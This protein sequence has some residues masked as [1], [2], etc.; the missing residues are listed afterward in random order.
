M[1]EIKRKTWDKYIETLRKLNDAAADAF[2][3][4]LKT[5]EIVTS[6]QRADAIMYA[7]GLATRY[8]EASAEFSARMYEAVARG[9][10]KTIEAALPAET[11]TYGEVAKTVNGCLKQSTNI[12]LIGNSIGRLVKQAG[13]DTVCQNAI[14][15][16]AEWAWVPEGDSCA[17]CMMLASN[18]WQRASKDVLK[19]NHAEHIHANCDCTFAIR[20]DSRTNVEGYD[21]DY[22]KDM[23]KDAEGNTWDE[24][25]N[26]LRREHYAAHREE[27]LAQQYAAEQPDA[28]IN[29]DL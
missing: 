25:I 29:E 2:K 22:Y 24:K 19:G 12:D 1:A 18:G 5:H 26:Y 15:D 14:R 3:E 11:A 23:F 17:F 8:G 27:I 13:V 9:S 4:Y 20:F 10:K 16:G 28:Q 7:Y 6:Q 21:P